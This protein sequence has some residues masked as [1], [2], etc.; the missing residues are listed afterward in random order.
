MLILQ[1]NVLN[2]IISPTRPKWSKSM[3]NWQ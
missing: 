1:K 2:V 3:H